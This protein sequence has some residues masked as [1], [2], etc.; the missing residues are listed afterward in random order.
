MTRRWNP[1]HRG[2]RNRL[3]SGLLLGLLMASLA[4]AAAPAL[5]T[6]DGQ[7]RA[8]IVLPAKPRPTESFAASELQRYVRKLSGAN[9]RVVKG[10]APG[11]A[12]RLHVGRT[13][14]ARSLAAERKLA[15]RDA[16]AFLVGASGDDVVM[17]GGCERGT[18]YAVYELLE[19]FGCLWLAPGVDHVPSRRT[20]AVPRR[21]AVVEP[22]FK[23]RVAR[24]ALVPAETDFEK[25]AL[26]WAVKRRVNFETWRKKAHLGESPEGVRIRGGFRGVNATHHTSHVFTRAVFR[27][28]P[29]WFGETAGTRKWSRRSQPCTTAPGVAEFFAGHINRFF[30]RRPDV[31]VFA[32]G[33]A[34][35][36]AFCQCKRCCALD[37]GEEWLHG[38]PVLTERWITFVNRIAALVAKRHPGKKIYTLAY[39]QT[40]RP[41]DPRR[42]RPAPNVLMHVVHSRPKYVCFIHE[43]ANAK[44][45]HNVKFLQALKKWT[46]MTRG[47]VMVY[48][49][50]PHSTFEQLPYGALQKVFRDIRTLRDAGAVGME[51]QT[52]AR[53]LGLYLPLIYGATAAM[54]DPDAS[55]DGT[56]GPFFKAMYGAAAPHVRAYCDYLESQRQACPEHCTDGILPYLKTPVVRR[57][58]E[59]MARAWQDADTAETRRRLQPLVDHQNLA[60]LQR[61][62]LDAFA[63][64]EA[65]GKVE[66]LRAAVEAAKAMKAMAEAIPK[67]GFRDNLGIYWRAVVWGRKG[68]VRRNLRRWTDLLEATTAKVP[69]RPGPK[70]GVL[71]LRAKTLVKALAKAGGLNPFLTPGLDPKAL[72]RCD[73]VVVSNLGRSPDGFNRARKRLRAWVSR[74]G[75]VLLLHDAVG[76]RR[77][78][79]L[80]PE[81]GKGKVHVRRREF[82]A[83][84]PHA[85]TAGVTTGKPFRHTYVDHVNVAPGPKGEAVILD[86]KR[87]PVVVC[88]SFG[89]GKVVLSGM[90]PGC[91]PKSV[92]REPAGM[93]LKV[94]ANSIRW[95]AER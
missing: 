10:D 48:D 24:F 94:L 27:K 82:L 41:P 25:V 43:L 76:Y 4:A 20:L 86:G 29:E 3:L 9:L 51:A 85:L 23:Y 87:Q 52:S 33:Q 71:G 81:V 72:K 64:Y 75:R 8:V 79:A 38:R 74:G 67:D 95:L 18:L 37:T 19:R 62:A 68:L 83:A 2:Q 63:R 89:R 11:G 57:A 17:I 80:F 91:G 49:Y 35:G 88:G 46:G 44:C 7:P 15:A 84:K 12:V 77:H 66:H 22:V 16:E 56:M 58:D 55:L 70:V 73:V 5:V 28:H 60:G 21:L 78:K 13:P 54:W 59:L 1:T 31:E 40:M 30:D 14:R 36:T 47:G 65:T 69:D 26:D 50:Y 45:P 92:E 6:K 39:H 90:L 61:D 34:D 53:I 42:L 93:E 32:M